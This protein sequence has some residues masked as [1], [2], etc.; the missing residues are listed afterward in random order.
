M[1]YA[2][3]GIYFALFAGFIAFF[4]RESRR[5]PPDNGWLRQSNFTDDFH[6]P[7]DAA[8]VQFRPHPPCA[9]SRRVES[10]QR[11]FSRFEVVGG[12]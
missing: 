4:E 10:S 12:E 9:G 7:Q 2:I 5:C 6:L 8:S 1:T 11:I 3:A